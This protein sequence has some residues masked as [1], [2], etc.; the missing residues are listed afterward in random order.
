MGTASKRGFANNGSSGIIVEDF[1]GDGIDDFFIANASVKLKNGKF[2]YDGINPVMISTG[3]FKWKASTHT[4][5]KT[6]KKTKTYNGFSARGDAGDIDNDGDIDVITTD[7]DKES[8]VIIMM[9]KETS[10]QSS[11]STIA[12]V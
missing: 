9:V 10:T 8:S 6:D 1:N 2:S 7:V 3:P 11:V 5:F 4:G 12:L